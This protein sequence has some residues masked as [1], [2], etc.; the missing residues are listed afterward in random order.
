MI[1]APRPALA[2]GLLFAAPAALAH[3]AAAAGGGLEML[4]LLLLLLLGAA[5]VALGLRR[6]RSGALARP[7]RGLRDRV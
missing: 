7:L 2:L 4:L 5:A 3:E 1:P 6:W